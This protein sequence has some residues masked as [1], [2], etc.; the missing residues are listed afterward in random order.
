MLVHKYFNL[1]WVTLQHFQ[2]LS[3][4]LDDFVKGIA[5]LSNMLWFAKRITDRLILVDFL[6]EPSLEFLLRHTDHEISDKF[7]DRL[8]HRPDRDLKHCIDTGANLLDENV[9][10]ASIR[11]LLLLLLLLGRLRN[12]LAVLVVLGRHVVF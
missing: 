12:Y 8:T 10:A 6:V 9:G 7:G 2:R 4:R 5:S 1:L 11:L 3:E